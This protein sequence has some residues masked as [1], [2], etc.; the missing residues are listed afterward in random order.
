MISK[1][2]KQYF[3]GSSKEEKVRKFE[4]LESIMATSRHDLDVAVKGLNVI[5][6]N[7]D[8]IKKSASIV[9]GTPGVTPDNVAVAL[10]NMRFSDG[11]LTEYMDGF[12]HTTKAHKVALE[13][14]EKEMAVLIGENPNMADIIIDVMHDDGIEKALETVFMAYKDGSVDRKLAVAAYHTAMAN[15]RTDRD[16]SPLLD[17]H[18]KDN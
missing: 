18:L 8:E 16:L 3:H 2:I 7:V 11:N 6:A 17:K 5:I 14:A 1:Y 13:K 15:R 4:E 12:S 10:D 9:I